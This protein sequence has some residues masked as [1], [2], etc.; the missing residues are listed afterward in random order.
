M[1][2]GV[3]SPVLPGRWIQHSRLRHVGASLPGPAAWCRNASPGRGA[4]LEL[5]VYM[6]R[7]P[8]VLPSKVSLSIGAL[9]FRLVMAAV[10]TTCG[11]LVV[12]A[13]THAAT[14]CWPLELWAPIGGAGI[15][16]TFGFRGS[17]FRG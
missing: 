14:T 13:R 16:E 6:G 5:L 3:Y 11:H 7:N 12:A 8:R 4:L 15:Y 17:E 2:F 10:A 1:F 9:L